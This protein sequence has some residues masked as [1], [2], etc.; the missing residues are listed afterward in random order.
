MGRASISLHFGRGEP[1]SDD[2]IDYVGEDDAWLFDEVVNPLVF[3]LL[4]L[5]IPLGMFIAL[6]KDPWGA[7]ASNNIVL[8]DKVVA[9]RY[10]CI[11]RRDSAWENYWS[12]GAAATQPDMGP[13]FSLRLATRLVNGR[14]ARQAAQRNAG[15]RCGLRI[16]FGPRRD[17]AKVSSNLFVTG[18]AFGMRFIKSASER[19]EQMETPVTAVVSDG[20]PGHVGPGYNPP[21]LSL[22]GSVYIDDW[23]YVNYGNKVP[24]I[25]LS[26]LELTYAEPPASLSPSRIEARTPQFMHSWSGIWTHLEWHELN[27]SNNYL[28]FP[29]PISI[30]PGEGRMLALAPWGGG[31]DIYYAADGKHERASLIVEQ[32]SAPLHFYIHERGAAAN[33][34]WFHPGPI[35]TLNTLSVGDG[36]ASDQP[37]FYW[38]SFRIRDVVELVAKGKNEPVK[39]DPKTGEPIRWNLTWPRLRI[40][41]PGVV[42]LYLRLPIVVVEGEAFTSPMAP[43]STQEIGGGVVSMTRNFLESPAEYEKFV[44]GSGD[45]FRDGFYAPRGA[46]F[47]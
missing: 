34:S 31:N 12:M 44:G 42:P 30:S 8:C 43:G 6:F 28:H 26:L 25:W 37:D 24:L 19:A 14:A 7:V 10:S 11:D 16:L 1:P 5:F 21:A 36:R 17:L 35:V 27:H 2:L 41:N 4:N 45:L 29:E 3:E 23:V 39:F 38:T 32:P 18:A 40:S 22:G 47:E 46:L 20:G 15:P 33:Y 9:L 13:R